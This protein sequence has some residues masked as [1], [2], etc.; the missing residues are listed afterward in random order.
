[1]T[2]AGEGSR[3]ELDGGCGCGAVRY[4]LASAPMYVHCCHCT[5][6]QRQTGSA[7]AV[8]ALI[9]ANRITVL[10]GEVCEVVLPT[11]SGGGLA[12]QQCGACGAIL[13]MHYSGAG[14]GVAFLRVGTLDEPAAFPPDIHIF[15]RSKQPWMRLPDET[16][17]VEGYY[18]IR[19]IWPED[20]F[21]RLIA[22]KEAAGK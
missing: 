12:T 11:E 5:E 20:R 7:F 18:P 2:A 1:V 22:A 14:R 8:N 13:W 17:A 10:Q 21:A 4:R 6:C 15:T 3:S 16:L 19:E 9:E